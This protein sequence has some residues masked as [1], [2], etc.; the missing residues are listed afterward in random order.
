MIK[1]TCPE[2][3]LENE[4]E[5]IY[6]HECGA[7]LDR[8][9]LA[10]AVSKE[11]KPQETHKRLKSMFNPQGVILRRNFFTTSK[12]V[13][14]ALA[15]AAVVQ[16]LLPPDLP[17]R[18]KSV[19]LAA[20][21]GLD[22]ETASTTAAAAPLRYSEEQVNAYLASALKGKQAALSSYL[23]FER[24]I[25]RFDEN[26]CAVT[27]ERSLFGYSVFTGAT[28]RAALQNGAIVA[29]T[30][31]GSIGRLPI[32]PQL[33]RLT[34]PFFSGLW[35]AFERERKSLVKMGT[36]EFHPQSVVIAPKR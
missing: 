23:K 7:K 17:P 2:C 36:L 27:I 21:I 13:L 5:R 8:S 14:G 24:A 28:Y 6:C 11:E 3:R 1:L 19:G 20:Q 9:A 34:E 30:R 16:M 12:V 26:L 10:K 35:M 15:T 31:G 18:T 22:L 4:P 29:Q 32:H 25:A 33:L